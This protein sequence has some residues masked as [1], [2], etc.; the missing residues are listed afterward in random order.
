[1][2]INVIFT[3][4]GHSFKLASTF[5][6]NQAFLCHAADCKL[7]ITH[8]KC[9]EKITGE[10][11]M[12]MAVQSIAHGNYDIRVTTL[13][14]ME[15]TKLKLVFI[16]ENKQNNLSLPAHNCVTFHHNPLFS[17]VPCLLHY[18]L[19]DYRI[20]SYNVAYLLSVLYSFSELLVKQT[21]SKNRRPISYSDMCVN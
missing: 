13:Q 12:E 18:I 19:T 6:C 15:R 2:K 7:K 3:V 11:I 17:I 1:M 8:C 9:S 5:Q 20:L 16:T 4:K 10:V 14:C 21:S